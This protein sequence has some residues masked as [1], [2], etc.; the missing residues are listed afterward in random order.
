MNSSQCSPRSEAVRA[1]F[2]ATPKSSDE[3]RAGTVVTP[4]RMIVEVGIRRF[5]RT[6]RPSAATLDVYM[7]TRGAVQ[8]PINSGSRSGSITGPYD[9]RPP[10]KVNKRYYGRPP[11]RR[12]NLANES[13]GATRS[14]YA[15]RR[16]ERAE[17]GVFDDSGR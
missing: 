11:T 13:R 1:C 3:R 6:G 17:S 16:S 9:R 10:T 7:L 12:P 4:Y 5:R 2:C 15:R 14:P 8:S